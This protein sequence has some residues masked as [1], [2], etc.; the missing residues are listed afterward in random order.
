[1]AFVG[2]GGVGAARSVE[3]V[4]LICV[5]LQRASVHTNVTFKVASALRAARSPPT[6]PHH[7]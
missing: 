2:D 4:R 3:Q 6:E 7:A 5:E 1:V